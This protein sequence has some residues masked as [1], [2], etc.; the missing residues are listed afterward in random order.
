MSYSSLIQA[1]P[2]AWRSSNGIAALGSLGVHMLLVVLLPLVH[3]DDPKNDLQQTVGLVE[4]SPEELSRL[5]GVIPQQAPL[6]S[7]ATQQSQL[8]PMPS[9]PALQSDVLPPLPPPPSFL[10]PPPPSN[11]P[12]YQYPPSN[13]PP[14]PQIPVQVPLPPP[15]SNQSVISPSEPNQNLRVRDLSPLPP[16]AIPP[17]Q[18]L[19]ST[20]GIK[21]GEPFSP[22]ANQPN[23][24]PQQ[25]TNQT[26]NQIAINNRANQQTPRLA[27]STLPERTKQELIARRNAI[28][29]ERLATKR[30]VTPDSERSQRLAALQQRL[31]QQGD[32]TNIN[33]AIPPN[34][35]R[36]QRLA[37]LQQ[38]LRQQGDRTAS[39]PATVTPQSD[40]NQR[41]AAALQRQ[42]QNPVSPPSQLSVA[43]TQTIAQL[44]AFKEI[45]QAY[46]TAVIQPP[47]RYKI[48]TCKKQLD[49]SVAVL[50]A[51]V[52]P[53]G[54]IISGPDLLSKQTPVPVQQSAV[55]FVNK[56]QFPKTSNQT[57]QPFRLEFTYD[58]SCPVTTKQQDNS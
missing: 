38:R 21:P 14:Q 5:Q 4:L 54:K 35:D 41:L 2:E 44:D 9:F 6:P 1:L 17:N 7:S 18:N 42:Q 48:K 20:T 3:F 26:Q 56:Y 12:I 46:P 27:P 49:G 22:T 55:A 16:N 30:T 33:P 28:S 24:I 45:Q 19:P 32:R 37:A 13:F 39:S 47:I 53:E 51:V 43:A 50:T 11:A 34:S 8:P 57:N 58:S 23:S 25:N 31:R 29:Q 52:S 36:S 40:S 10:P 15:P